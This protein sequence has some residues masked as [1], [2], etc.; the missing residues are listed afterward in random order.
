MASGPKRIRRRTRLNRR[1]INIRTLLADREFIK[2]T[3]FVL[4]HRIKARVLDMLERLRRDRM[5]LRLRA[6]PDRSPALPEMTDGEAVREINWRLGTLPPGDAETVARYIRHL[7]RWYTERRKKAARARRRQA[8][9][10][11]APR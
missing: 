7:T 9:S 10:L 4:P 2:V 1:A 8:M 11:P 3:A 6:D 5:D